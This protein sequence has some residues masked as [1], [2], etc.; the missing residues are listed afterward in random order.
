MHG[1]ASHSSGHRL[2]QSMFAKHRG[3]KGP[4]GVGFL[5]GLN[6]GRTSPTHDIKLGV[7][8]PNNGGTKGGGLHSGVG[9]EASEKG[10]ENVVERTAVP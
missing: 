10:K 5:E 9:R 1:E 3:G 2:F 8:A 4:P 6:S 7:A